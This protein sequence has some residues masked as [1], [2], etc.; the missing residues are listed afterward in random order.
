MST[1]DDLLSE[2]S[3]VPEYFRSS[4]RR[5]L[6]RCGE[7]LQVLRTFPALSI[8][9]CMT[10]PPYWGQRAYDS[11]GIGQES[12]F[13]EYIRHLLAIFAEVKR[14]LKPAG[15]FWLNIGDSYQSKCLL[16]LPWRVALA[17]TDDHGWLLRNSVVWNKVK[18][19]PDNA[20]DK[21][22]SVHEFVFHFVKG[23]RYFY[24]ADAIRKKPGQA[25]VVNG[26]V[27]SATGVSGIRYRRQI[28]LS[29][30]LSATEKSAAFAALETILDEIRSGK[31]A[32]FRMIIRGQQRVTHS[33]SDRVSGRARELAEKG[34]YFL[35]YNPNGSK[36]GDVWDIIPEDTQR[37]K[38]HFAPYPEDLCRVPILATCPEGGVVLDP[39]TGTGPAPV[40]RNAPKATKIA[41]L[42]GLPTGQPANWGTIVSEQRC[43]FLGRKCEKNRK[44]D[45][46]VTI[47]TCAML[48]GRAPRPM[49][50]CPFRLLERRQLFRD[51]IHLLKQHEPGNE[52]RIVTQIPVPG[53]SVDYGLVSARGGKVRDFVGIEIQALDTTGTVWPERQRFLRGNGIPARSEDVASRN[54]FGMN[55]KMTAKTTLGQLHHK[56][57]PFD[58]V[59]KRFVLV[60]QDFLMDYLRKEYDFD[61]VK[62]QRDSDTMQ[63]HAYEFRE[64]DTSYLMNLKERFSTDV[65]GT[66]LCLGLRADT[67]VELK[68]ILETRLNYQRVS[69]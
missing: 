39:F 22:R 64:Q 3:S 67:K 28:E 20:N 50:I 43:P 49:V 54:P 29:T 15:S 38:I 61:H 17:M 69:R 33:D 36:P 46:K 10:S 5:P 66:A 45:P 30:S 4:D 52:L 18:G 23:D 59:C 47:G 44:S 26:S 55:W 12:D 2:R 19:G 40:M 56:V 35:K 7:S 48:H 58:H 27:V 11:G 57:S 63:F 60:L 9:C 65:A 21:L 68:F 6:F 62:G 53:G 51:C 24:D 31:L 1:A 34:Y 14:V 32:D 42:Y 16:G 8:D 41:E 37:R 13:G 25:R